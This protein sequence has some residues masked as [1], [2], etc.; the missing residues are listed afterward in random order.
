[1]EK[2]SV[3]LIVWLRK[4]FAEIG[5]RVRIKVGELEWHISGKDRRY[6]LATK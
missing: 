3:F 2:K 4:W 6:N 5:G 1:V